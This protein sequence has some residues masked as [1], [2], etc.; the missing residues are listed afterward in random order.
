MLGIEVRDV[1]S[2]VLGKIRECG[3]C[4]R[5]GTVSEVDIGHHVFVS[6]KQSLQST[7]FLYVH[8]HSKRN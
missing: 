4:A 2:E 1:F 8:R 6:S 5:C 3:P 7:P